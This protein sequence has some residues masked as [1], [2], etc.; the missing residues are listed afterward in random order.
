MSTKEQSSS[1]GSTSCII[2]IRCST[3]KQSKNGLSLETQMTQCEALAKQRGLYVRKMFMDEG[4]S[5]AT[6]K[7]RDGLKDALDALS[8][9][10]TLLVYS[11]SRLMRDDDVKSFIHKKVS[12]KKAKI[13]SVSEPIDGSYSGEV[14]IDVMSALFKHELRVIADRVKGGMETKKKNDGT[15]NSRTKYGYRY[16]KTQRDPETGHFKIVPVPYEQKVIRI[17]K[18]M[19][20]TPYHA[21]NAKSKGSDTPYEVIADYL[22][23]KGY[24]TRY[25]DKATGKYKK[26]HSTTV[27]NIY[28]EEKDKET[29]ILDDSDDEEEEQKVVIRDIIYI[30]IRGPFKKYFG[31]LPS[32]PDLYNNEKKKDAKVYVF[33]CEHYKSDGN[34]LKVWLTAHKYIDDEDLMIN[35]T[36]DLNII[37]NRIKEHTKR[38]MIET[39]VKDMPVLFPE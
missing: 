11:L 25:M 15:C 2:Y 14:I 5:G 32:P 34:S 17:I 38:E 39:I 18:D 35:P 36:I 9:G 7:N 1:S 31:Y 27:R 3:N 33:P 13:A 6:L 16:D 37:I 30:I 23:E 10:D 28:L 19:R 12:E 29:V 20:K 4:K 21:E 22:N 8:E 26:W 24:H